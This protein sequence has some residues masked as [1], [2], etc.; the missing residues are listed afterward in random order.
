MI[1]QRLREETRAAH[2]AIE[3]DLEA[4]G[5]HRSLDRHRLLVARFFGFYTA[6]EPQ[7]ASSLADESFFSPRRK[8]PLLEQDLEFLGYD[9]AMIEALPR[10]SNPPGLTSL[11]ETLGSL[12]VLEGSTLGG[13][14]IAH[15]LE[16]SLGLSDGRGYSYFRSYGRE[17]GAMWRAFGA[18]LGALPAAAG[19]ASVRSAQLT[20]ARLHTWLCD[21]V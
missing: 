1:L 11:P 21:G 15:R 4:F 9:R 17:V 8:L 18:R 13:Q 14:V 7:V 6:W 3:R 5:A 19:D 20:F 2:D 10:C 12:Y 16:R